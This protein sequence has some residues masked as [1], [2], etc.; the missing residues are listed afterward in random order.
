MRQENPQSRIYVIDSQRTVMNSKT[1]KSQRL[2]GFVKEQFAAAA[3]SPVPILKEDCQSDN[4]CPSKV[5]R[6]RSQTQIHIPATCI[7]ESCRHD[8]SHSAHYFFV[9]VTQHTSNFSPEWSHLQCPPKSLLKSRTVS[10]D[11]Q[12]ALQ[13]VGRILLLTHT[14]RHL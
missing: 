13:I 7:K 1:H 9:L 14:I 5:A 10:S 3:G 12:A 4:R 11:H 2:K 6:S 8:G